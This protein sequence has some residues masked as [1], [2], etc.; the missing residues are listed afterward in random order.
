[1]RL[2]GKV[3]LISG[4]ARGMGAAE[5]RLFAREGAHV[6]LG[7]VLHQQGQAV[8]AKINDAGGQAL[9]VPLDVTSE[10][11]W[12]Q[13]VNA[14]VQRFGKLNVLVNNAGILVREELEE[15]TDHGWDSTM[16]VNAKGV[17]LGAKSAVP[18]MR[19]AGGGSIINISSISGIVLPRLPRLQ[20]LQG[21]R[22]TPHQK[23]RHPIRPAKHPRKLHPPRRNQHR[24]DGRR[25][26]FRRRLGPPHPPRPI[27]RTHRSRLRRTLPRLRRV[28]LHDRQRA[29]HRRRLHRPIAESK[30]QSYQ[31]PRNRIY[32]ETNAN[33]LI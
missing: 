6:V 7:D 30:M 14:A 32:T 22:P 18:A 2:Q 13:A 11:S 27:R 19:E 5:A 4:A 9:F 10:D 17:Y 21:S 23:H 26:P 25:H 12:R 20:R 16:N 1:M 3:A 28:L 33:C 15:G 31:R 8:A 24:H 29:C